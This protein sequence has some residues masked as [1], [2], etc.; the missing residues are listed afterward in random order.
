[1]ILTKALA[2]SVVVAL[3]WAGVA[4]WRVIVLTDER[5]ELRNII[6]AH[7]AAGRAWEAV[8]R[9][10]EKEA[11]NAINEARQWGQSEHDR[12]DRIARERAVRLRNAPSGA[13][14]D[15]GVPAGGDFRE[16]LA[17]CHERLRDAGDE[18]RGAIV[19]FESLAAA[20]R[21]AAVIDEERRRVLAST[22]CVQP[23]P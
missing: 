21:S 1:V 15:G 6:K 8:Y 5:D 14:A 4:S 19:A 11:Q 17:I 22:P 10:Q 3:A 20:I 18:A 16:A 23:K 2:I 7:E 13:P 12:A 9:Q